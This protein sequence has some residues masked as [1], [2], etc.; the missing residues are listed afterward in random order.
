MTTVSDI[1]VAVLNL[2]KGKYPTYKRY[3]NEVTE[4]FDKPSFFVS[5]QPTINSN[6][7]V[8]F[9]KY[10]YSIVIT[11]FQEKAK[12][13]DNMQ[14]V[15]EIE[16]LFGYQMPVK[17]K[18]INITNYDYQF[19]GNNNNILQITVDVE[20]YDAIKRIPTEPNV[21]ELKLNV[22]ER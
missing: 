20:F 21:N 9:K 8:N 16:E 2:L 18:L 13:T 6:E 10:G 22:E 14:K 15:A 5:I 7:S 12:E 19:V 4:G 1:R 3:G 17:N 11:Y